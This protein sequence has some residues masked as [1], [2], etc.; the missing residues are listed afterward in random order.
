MKGF[1]ALF[2]VVLTFPLLDAE[3]NYAGIALQCLCI[4]FGIQKTNGRNEGRVH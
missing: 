2:K 3:V 1:K 4:N